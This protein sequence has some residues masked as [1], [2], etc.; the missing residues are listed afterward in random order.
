MRFAELNEFFSSLSNATDDLKKVLPRHVSAITKIITDIISSD[1][2]DY[3][4]RVSASTAVMNMSNSC[5]KLFLNSKDLRN[6]YFEAIFKMIMIIPACEDFETY[7]SMTDEEITEWDNE[8]QDGIYTSSL[9]TLSN[10]AIAVGG[11]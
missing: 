9:E 3:S 10:F 2:A 1:N 11:K 7:M 6:Y 8:N 5:P 4:L